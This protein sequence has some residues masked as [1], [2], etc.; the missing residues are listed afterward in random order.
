MNMI[1]GMIIKGIGGFYYVHTAQGIVECKARGKFRKTIGKPIIGDQVTLELQPDGTGYL[2]EIAPRR[3]A[4]IRPAVANID[5]VAAVASAAP[6]VTDP[7]LIDKVSAIAAHKD[8]EMLVIFNK[9]DVDDAAELQKVYEQAG[10]A[11]LCVSAHTGQGIEALQKKLAGKTTALAGNSGVGKSSLVYALTGIAAEVGEISRISRG[12]HT[13][14]HVELIAL[15]NGGYLADTPGFSSFETDQMDLVLA[16]DLQ[17]AFPEFDAYLGQCKFTGCA[18][19]CEKGC[20]VLQ[21]VN[22]GKIAPSR[23]T[24]Y[25]KLYNSVKDMKQWEISKG[26]TR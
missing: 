15:P 20:A 12:K 10:I 22:A 8:M 16:E 25:V 3:N 21:A 14:R 17:Y 23:H 2:Q 4:L 7:F 26:G 19:V 1:N 5:L 13:T 9:C 6:P 18:H 24:S 11:V